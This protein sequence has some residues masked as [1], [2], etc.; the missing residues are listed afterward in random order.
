M[1][2][3]ASN[4]ASSGVRGHSG[5]VAIYLAATQPTL[6]RAL[7]LINAYARAVRG[8]DYPHGIP[9]DRY[10]LFVESLIHPA[11]VVAVEGAD[12]LPLM[13]PSRLET[14]PSRA[15]APSG[16]PRSS[17]ATA[18]AMLML[19]RRSDVRELL[20]EI[21]VPTL[22]VHARDNRFVGARS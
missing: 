11:P 7:I 5:P 21:Q 9:L 16:A 1:K 22:V 14:P 4:E 8:D 3:A 19:A 2:A 13:A 12:D 15:V 18:L 17:P 20:P 10:N 6:V